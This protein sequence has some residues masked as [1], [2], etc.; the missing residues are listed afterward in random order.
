M[1]QL[2]KTVFKA[3]SFEEADNDRAYWLLKTASERL[4][5]AWYLSCVAFG[6]DPNEIQTMKKDVFSM[7][8]R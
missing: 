6:L 1:Y 3:Q 4:Q 2:D 8:E 7:R 5:A